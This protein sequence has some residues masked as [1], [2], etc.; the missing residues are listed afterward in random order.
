MKRQ[1]IVQM[2]LAGAVA[3]ALAGCGGGGDPPQSAAVVPLAPTY[4][5]GGTVSGLAG[6][7][8]VL[9]NNG[10]GDLSLG[11]NGTFSFA[12]PEAAGA[13]YSVSVKVQPTTPSQTCTVGNGAGSVGAV[14][15][16]G[17]TVTCATLAGGALDAGFAAGG[18][19][20][21]PPGEAKGVVIQADAK[22]VVVALGPYANGNSFTLTRFNPDGSVDPS[23]GVAGKVAGNLGGLN[24]A[25][26]EVMA[27][28]LQGD[29]KLV[30][31][32]TGTGLVNGA[33]NREFALARYDA[34]GQ[35][36]GSFGVGGKVFASFNNGR[37]SDLRALVIQADGKLTAA[38]NTPGT[39]NDYNF[40]LARFLSDGSL[41][42]TF[43]SGGTVV[44]DLSGAGNDNAAE[45]LA[46][47]AD[48]KIV[49]AGW[50]QL[51]GS[52]SDVVAALARYN[53]DG[54]LDSTFGV[55]GQLSDT[56][57]ID[58]YGGPAS[59]A[60]QADG[61]IV[62]GKNVDSAGVDFALS[63]Y[64]ANGT[65]DASFG[66]NG[67]VTTDFGGASQDRSQTM[68]IQAD[69]K[70]IVA[71]ASPL[72]QSGP[73]FALARYRADG[74]L[75][76]SFGSGGKVLTDFGVSFAIV[77]ALA[78]QADG[79]IVAVGGASNGTWFAAVARYAP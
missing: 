19:F 27:L 10:A 64:N 48:G 54:S 47:Q 70:I 11:A 9:Q 30:V 59:V 29:G 39:R 50:N 40:A 52:G 58:D 49:V 71:G 41:D 28:A 21:L 36:D 63:R 45:S 1:W 22:I 61:K 46:L 37:S 56:G 55:A 17:V 43:G 13:L 53:P 66:V 25:G 23:F 57:L 15:V 51:G 32:G 35:L 14:D 38:G 76:T 20:L 5:I 69:G 44:T 7:G 12:A 79:K 34:A 77:D 60:I 62:L 74:S 4:T 18:K 31:A 16:T 72:D 78:I 24:L 65:P 42:A 26:E 33:G 3:A 6:S 8:L 75:D 68:R 2:W 67:V 73:V